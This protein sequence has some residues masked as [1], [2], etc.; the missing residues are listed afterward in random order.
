MFVAI[1]PKIGTFGVSFCVLVNFGVLFSGILY[2]W[3]NITT[4]Y[5][6]YCNIVFYRNTVSKVIVTVVTV[7][8]FK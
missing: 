6:F 3:Y 4:F 8:I 7:L 2:V 5:P 1:G